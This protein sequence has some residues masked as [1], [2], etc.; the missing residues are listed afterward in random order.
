MHPLAH[1]DLQ[2]FYELLINQETAVRNFVAF[3]E[4]P[5]KIAEERFPVIRVHEPKPSHRQ[6]VPVGTRVPRPCTS[7]LDMLYPLF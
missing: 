4:M 1:D 6:K 2:L 3:E 5:R 7:E